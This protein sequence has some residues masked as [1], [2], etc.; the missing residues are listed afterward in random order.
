MSVQH[1]AMPDFLND[2]L[3]SQTPP[4]ELMR[5]AEADPTQAT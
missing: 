5:Q 2:A 1:F 4:I 3:S